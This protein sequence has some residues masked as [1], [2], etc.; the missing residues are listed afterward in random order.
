MRV[1]FVGVI[2][3]VGPSTKWNGIRKVLKSANWP[4]EIYSEVTINEY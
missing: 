4:Y 2:E 1:Y 3:E